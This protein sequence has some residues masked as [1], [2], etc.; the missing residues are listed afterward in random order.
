MLCQIREGFLA[1]LGM[2]KYGET[3][4]IESRC[5]TA[6]ALASYFAAAFCFANSARNVCS[7][8]AT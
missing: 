8:S 6:P 3:L 2:T 5:P 4:F 1:A 7:R